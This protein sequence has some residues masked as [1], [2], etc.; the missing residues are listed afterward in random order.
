MD[1]VRYRQVAA[2]RVHSSPDGKRAI[3]PALFIPLS[4]IVA[5]WQVLP[6]PAGKSV[7]T[8]GATLLQDEVERRL[9]ATLPS[10]SADMAQ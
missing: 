9:K 2:P 3:T 6:S 5:A 4:R 8:S 10:K 1:A 7:Q